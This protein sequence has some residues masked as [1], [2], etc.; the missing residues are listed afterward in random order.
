MIQQIKGRVAKQAHVG[1]PEGLY[2]H[3]LGRQGF[4]GRVA[5][6]YRR[7]PPI[8]YTR[9]EGRLRTRALAGLQLSPSDRSDP[10]GGPVK[11]FYNDDLSYFVSR[12]S[13]PM[14]F[15]F[16]NADGDE[17]HFVHEGKGVME[18]EFGL[19]AYE[20]GD[21]LVVPKG[22]TYRVV[23][24]SSD[25]RLIIE[26]RGEVNL[27]DRGLVGQF[28]PFDTG[29]FVYPELQRIEDDGRKEYEVRVKREDELTSVFYPFC[30]LDVEGWKGTL[31]VFKFNIRDFRTLTSERVHL[32]PSAHVIFEAPG[33]LLGLFAP[34]P[35]E[36]EREAH[37]VP[38]YH[39]NVDF[40]EVYFVHSQKRGFDGRESPSAAFLM[41]PPGIDH[42]LPREVYDADREGTRRND[43]LDFYIVGVDARKPVRLTPEAEA[44]EV[45]R[46][47]G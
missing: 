15:Y 46:A 40:D 4:T 14:P 2:E 42:G 39:R 31:C 11:I 24:E 12:R 8:E 38:W 44:T 28:A 32:P 41:L 10:N 26:A 35:L 45:E 13:A 34:R 21:L 17:I 37:R 30:P 16:R 7:N 33:F 9:I 36:G 29:V 1:I 43:R 18:T 3:E 47:P 27:P 23:P 22:V 5:L 6:F 25:Y 20:P 19:L